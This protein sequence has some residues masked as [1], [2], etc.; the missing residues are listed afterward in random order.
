VCLALY[1]VDALLSVA[2]QTLTLALGVRALTGICGLVSV[3]VLLAGLMVYALMGITPMIP[4]RLFLP[5]ALFSPFA[6]LAFIPIVIYAYRWMEQANWVIALC[7]LA[8]GLIILGLLQGGFRW[9]WPLVPEKRLGPRAFS[10]MNL[11]GFLLVNLFVLLPAV[12]AYLGFS[13]AV[14]VHRATAG[15]L[16]LR[17]SGFMVQVR[18]YVRDDGRTV[19]LVPMAHVGEA[20]FYHQLSRSFPTN[21][22][23]LMEGVTDDQQL[24]TNRISY[25]RVAA[26]L[27]LSEQQREFKPVAVE[28]VR[29]DVDVSQFT[30]S[31]I[32]LLNLIML[33]HGKGLTTETISALLGFS[34][35]PHLE[36]QVWDDILRK[37]NER[38]LEE[39]HDRLGETKP[40]V[41]P[42]GV[43]H[44]PGIAVGITASGFRVAETQEY[45]VIRFHPGRASG[46]AERKR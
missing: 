42:W 38:V 27:G 1:L 41:V 20:E 6:M 46:A 22:V 3:L 21:S 28:M 29:A 7:Q 19:L 13:A 18:K 24:L 16:A 33:I 15:F 30:P 36:D 14:A 26:T 23:V 43:A 12:T 45:P 4:K 5:V 11:C 9:R 25:K 37:R 34:P 10:W 17:P 35:P 40:I 8:L 31:T 39:I 2:S 44:M 32:G